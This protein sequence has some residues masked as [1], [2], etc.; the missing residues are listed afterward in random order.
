LISNVS[1]E[2]LRLVKADQAGGG[3]DLAPVTLL[4]QGSL[5]ELARRAGLTSLDPRRFRMLMQFGPLGAH[6]E[7][8]WRD[9][10]VGIGE[11]QIR[12]GATVPRCAAT[13]RHPDRGVRDVPIVR[14][15]RAYRGVQT[16]GWGDGVPFGVYAQVVQGGRVRVGDEVEVLDRA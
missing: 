6:V 9:Q 10:V 5:D 7:D 2:T 14:A 1:G 4:G 16:T 12:V 3:S 13:T 11:A 8:G 15:I